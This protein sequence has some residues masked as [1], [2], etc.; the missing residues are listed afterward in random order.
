[1]LDIFIR[2]S[3]MWVETRRRELRL[4]VM[5]RLEKKF[6]TPPTHTHTHTIVHASLHLSALVIIF[7]QSALSLTIYGGKLKLR[8][9]G[10]WRQTVGIRFFLFGMCCNSLHVTF[11]SLYVSC[12]FFFLQE[13]YC[14]KRYNKYLGSLC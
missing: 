6:Y 5:T 13:A 12:V 14:V 7:S 3:V 9:I 1:M 11:T 4:R 2:Q 10:G 8:L